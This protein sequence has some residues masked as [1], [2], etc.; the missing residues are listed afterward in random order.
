MHHPLRHPRNAALV[1]IIFVIIGVIFWAVPT[2]EGLPEPSVEVAAG[3]TLLVFLGVAMVAGA[4]FVEDVRVLEAGAPR[5]VEMELRFGAGFAGVRAREHRIELYD[6]NGYVQIATAPIFAVDSR[7]ERKLLDV[8]VTQ[9]HATISVPDDLVAPI[10]VD[11][12]W[13]TRAS[14]GDSST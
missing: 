1:G 4:D 9:S 14:T 6:A 5:V 2:F 12:L 13:S 3:T 11:P 8:T 10:V 7:G